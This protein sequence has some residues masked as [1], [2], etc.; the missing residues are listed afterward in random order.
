MKKSR[1]LLNDDDQI[2][3]CLWALENVG[4]KKNVKLNFQSIVQF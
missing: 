1:S 2:A 4:W 3:R